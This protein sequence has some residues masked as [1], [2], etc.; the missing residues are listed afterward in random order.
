MPDS[1]PRH[2]VAWRPTPAYL[3][4]SRLRR[5]MEAQGI[6][7]YDELLRRAA[8]DPSWFWDAVVRDLGLAWYRP[9][10]QVL[11]LS[12]G[13]PWARWFSGGLYNYVHNALDK[14]A[15]GPRTADRPALV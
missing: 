14:H 10:T 7:G 1:T 4:R 13:V 12:D 5:F 11:D 9:Y 2:S 6:G 8:A 3:E 15:A